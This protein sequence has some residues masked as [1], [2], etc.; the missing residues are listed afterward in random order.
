[1]VL[2]SATS[3]HRSPSAG[4][5]AGF[6]GVLG[7]G[8][9]SIV[10]SSM[11]GWAACWFAVDFPGMVDRLVLISPAGLY[12]EG[13]PPMPV[14]RVVEEVEAYYSGLVAGDNLAG[15]KPGEEM[16]KGIETITAMD[17]AGGFKP[18]IAGRLSG[19][20]AKTLII[21]GRED[22]VVPAAYAEAFRKSI[23]RSELRL[24]S[25]A[26]HLSFADMPDEVNAMI[27]SFLG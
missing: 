9:A 8:M 19:I 14:S 7:I 1:M 5:L 27:A 26:G 6:M 11:G 10:A 22:R 2:K 15:L 4:F 12:F 20:E 21:W 25:G 3:R 17:E 13:E 23:P 24:L 18:D 16:R